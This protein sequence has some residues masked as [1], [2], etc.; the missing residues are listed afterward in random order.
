VR[1]LADPANAIELIVAKAP[2]SFYHDHVSPSAAPRGTSSQ[3]QTEHHFD[4]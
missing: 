4:G 3:S 2:R 1:D